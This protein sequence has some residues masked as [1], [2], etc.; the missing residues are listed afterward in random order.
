MGLDASYMYDPFPGEPEPPRP[1][2]TPYCKIC[3]EHHR[4]RCPSVKAI[5]YYPDGT[6]QRVE[7]YQPGK[8]PRTF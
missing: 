4:G 5:T 3:G 8:A 1:V 6:I 2:A 7:Y